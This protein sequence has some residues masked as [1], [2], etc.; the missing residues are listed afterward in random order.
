MCFA[1]RSD[2]VVVVG[3][4]KNRLGDKHV[5]LLFRGWGITTERGNFDGDDLNDDDE[6]ASINGQIPKMS[7][8]VHLCHYLATSVTILLKFGNN[9]RQEKKIAALV[10]FVNQNLFFE[11]FYHDGVER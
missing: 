5:A 9:R 11:I 4:E 3:L 2:V 7:P 1:S 8:I 10:T 6:T